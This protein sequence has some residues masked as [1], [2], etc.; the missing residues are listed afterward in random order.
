PSPATLDEIF[1]AGPGNFAPVPVT[2]D[3]LAAILY[4]SGTTADPKGVMLTQGNLQGEGDAILSWANIGPEDA[5][6]GILPLFH[7]LAQMANLFLPMVRG[8]RV[9]YLETL[10]TTEL[11]RAL[12]ERNITA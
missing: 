4:T 1:A 6:L 8:S 10:N 7:A 2:R 11:L 9:V 3:D 5:I 12:R